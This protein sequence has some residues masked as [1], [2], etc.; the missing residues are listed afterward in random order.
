[1]A[2]LPSGSLLWTQRE[3]ANATNSFSDKNRICEGTFADIYKGQ[4]NNMVFVIK[5]LKEASTAPFSRRGCVISMTCPLA[6][7]YYCVGKEPE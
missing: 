3:I 6:V 5:R 1:M 7:V 2:D 4:R